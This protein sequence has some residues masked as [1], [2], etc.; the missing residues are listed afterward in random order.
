MTSPM[1]R[2]ELR[3]R[4][5][6]FLDEYAR[7]KKLR[8]SLDMTRGKPSAA[9][10][11]LSAQLL[12]LPGGEYIADGMDVRNYGG[13]DGLDAARRLFAGILEAP[14][15]NIIIGGNSSLSMMFETLARACLFG[16]PGGGRAW[17][18]I[19]NKKF[20]CPA[21]GY[22]RHFAITE[23]L[24]FTLLDVPMRDDGPDMD[25]VE[26][27]AGGDD[28]VMG[29]W[30]VPK[31]HN[32]TGACYGADTAARLASMQTAAT[33]FRILWDNAYAEHHLFDARPAVVNIAQLCEAAGNAE[34]VVQFASTSKICHPGSGVA[35]MAAS[36][37]NIADAR[38]HLAAQTIGPDK[39]NQLRLLQFCGT[40]ERLRA[41][42]KKHAALLRPKFEAVWEI[43]ERELGG[44]G[45]AE[46]SKPRGGYF[47]SLDIPDG[48]ATRAVQLAGEAGVTLTAAG[49]P[50][51]YGKDPRDR[52]I[53]IAPTYPALADV[54]TACEALAVC[55]KLAA[56]E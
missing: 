5:R 7:L 12:A 16:A 48:C 54:R 31:Y 38:A 9:Q 28:S 39:V 1:P 8:L 33:D 41:H 10:L 35:A 21:P 25:A 30:C 2:A 44:L 32:P 50:F 13:A 47:I 14:K 20:I 22:D 4:R 43:L 23:H 19:E 3:A 55:V 26:A 24:G 49:A 29:I 56:S 27:L 46:W 52:N 15:D 36:D 51:P 6:Q 11:D 42:M 37:A 45:I 34:R 53:R 18:R 17:S 40:L